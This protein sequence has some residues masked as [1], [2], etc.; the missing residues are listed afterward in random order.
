VDAGAVGIVLLAPALLLAKA[1][2]VS[3]EALANV[4]AEVRT[5]LSFIVLQTMSDTFS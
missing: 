3:A 2:H 1:T 5:P 4:H